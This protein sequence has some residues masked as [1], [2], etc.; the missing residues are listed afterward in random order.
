MHGRETAVL[1]FEAEPYKYCSVGRKDERR[2]L[3][4]G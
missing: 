1:L 4:D 2:Y 3:S